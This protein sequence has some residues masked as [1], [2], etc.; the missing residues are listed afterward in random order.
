MF[1]RDC[2]IHT[3]FS[4]GA[5]TP[6]EMLCAALAQGLTTVGFSDHS[7]TSFDLSWCMAPDRVPA[8]RAAIAALKEKYRSR[9]EVLCGIEQDYYADAPAEGYDFVIGSVHYLRVGDDYLPVDESAELLRAAADRC[10]GGDIY[11]LVEAYFCTVADVVRVTGATVVGHFDLI[12]KFNE[13]TPLFDENHPRYV[14]AWRAAADALL[15]T[16]VPFEKNVGAVLRGW[17]S[18]A[19]PAPPIEAYLRAGGARL[20]W[21]SDAHSAAAFKDCS[22][23]GD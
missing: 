20:P 14:A 4:D 2:H 9:A 11:A 12:A 1:T 10:F 21:A 19:Y 22:Q 7:P 3:V 16:G 6:E 15:A 8:Y 5:D 18:V 23:F 17:R 13:Q